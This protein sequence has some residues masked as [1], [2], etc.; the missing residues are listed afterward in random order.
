MSTTTTP[1]I[2]AARLWTGRILS[3]L[4]AAMLFLDAGM[5]VIKHEEVM[6]KTAEMGFPESAIMPMGLSLLAGVI[7]Y[8]IPQTAPIG[9][10]LIAAYLGGAVCTH[11]VRSDPVWQILMP[12]V[13]GVV[14]WIGL[15]LRD[16][17]L[18]VLLPWKR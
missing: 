18:D 13:F 10:T 4:P 17:R 1:P 14:I 8:L 7:L 12:A 3:F 6:K 9:A 15:V 5:K 16:P 11:L 2:S